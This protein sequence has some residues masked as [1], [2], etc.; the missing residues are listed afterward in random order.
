MESTF[1][2]F[3]EVYRARHAPEAHAMRLGL[4]AAGL[5][6]KCG[7]RCVVIAALVMIGA[8]SRSVLE[9]GGGGGGGGGGEG[10]GVTAMGPLP[11]PL[12][13]PQP[14]SINAASETPKITLVRIT[15]SSAPPKRA[16]AT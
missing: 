9:V 10:G 12:L 8:I 15:Y 2:Q 13:P 5:I 11:A 1:Q 16:N 3:V 6:V 4:E 7:V 14:A